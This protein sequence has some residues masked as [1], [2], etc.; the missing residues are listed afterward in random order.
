ML[1]RHSHDVI[2]PKKR[3]RVYIAGPMSG[4]HDLNRAAFADAEEA[5]QGDGVNPHQVCEVRGLTKYEDCMRADLRALLSCDAVLMLPGW[6]Q[7]RGARHE[8][9]T[10]MI[11]G[12]PIYYDLVLTRA[13]V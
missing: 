4:C 5:L 6:E 9:E 2:K 7:S 12:I 3:R 13:P 8:H 11:C 10:A 1:G